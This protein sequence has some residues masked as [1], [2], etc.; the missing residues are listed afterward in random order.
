[1][2]ELVYTPIS[3]VSPGG[4]R[5][6]AVDLSSALETGE[7]VATEGVTAADA[8]V[9]TVSSVSSSSQTISF[10]VAVAAGA[11]AG[12]QYIYVAF[13]GSSGSNDTYKVRLPVVDYLTE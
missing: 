5:D 12:N 10:H 3:S 7:T 8:A 9:I 11:S 2:A 1:M 4:E 6:L 13:T